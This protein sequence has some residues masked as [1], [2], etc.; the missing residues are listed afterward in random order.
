MSTMEEDVRTNEL[1]IDLVVLIVLFNT[2]RPNVA[3]EAD[4]A[5]ITKHNQFYRDLLL[6][7]V[8]AECYCSVVQLSESFANCQHLPI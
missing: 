2:E 7:C 1:A 4:G 6:R 3:L 8:H 5:T